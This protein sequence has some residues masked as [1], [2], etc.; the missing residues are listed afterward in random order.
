M[1][2]IKLTEDE[3]A[4]AKAIS[5]VRMKYSYRHGHKATVFGNKNEYKT[6]ID[7]FGGE[8]AF[9]RAFGLP[10]DKKE[11]PSGQDFILPNSGI[12]VDVKVNSNPRKN[13]DLLVGTR[14]RINPT[15]IYVL[16][17][18]PCPNYEIIGY[19]PK[20]MIMDDS[21]IA[22]V[23]VTYPV[24]ISQAELYTDF[25]KL[26]NLKE[27][28]EYPWT[29][30]QKIQTDALKTRVYFPENLHSRRVIKLEI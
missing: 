19:A 11:Y 16:L 21:Y 15:D 23:G 4:Q 24:V 6:K 26:M 10:V 18:G 30:N 29:Q 20:Y 12:T 13:I 14:K 8:I 5:L 1:I 28:D 7:G 22:R 9:G 25:E 27:G 17:R 3:V 2:K